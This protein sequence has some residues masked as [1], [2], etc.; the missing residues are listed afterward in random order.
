MLE[1]QLARGFLV[2]RGILGGRHLDRAHSQPADAGET[3]QGSGYALGNTTAHFLVGAPGDR[4]E[5][6]PAPAVL[7]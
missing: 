6:Q 2:K 4:S 7:S 3:Q 1:A 5:E